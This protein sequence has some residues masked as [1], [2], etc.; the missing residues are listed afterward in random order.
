[1]VRYS[2]REAEEMY[3]NMNA[4][5]REITGLDVETIRA[6]KA[7]HALA[8]KYAEYLVTT[9]DLSGYEGDPHD[10][11]NWDGRYY[12]E[13]ILPSHTVTEN[14]KLLDNITLGRITVNY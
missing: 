14:E 8:S 6:I 10:L 7:K 9:V 1:M 5:Q 2:S 13:V 12:Q 4:Q 11:L 3:G